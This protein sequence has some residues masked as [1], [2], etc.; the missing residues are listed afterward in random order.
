[1][2]KATISDVVHAFLG[3]PRCKELLEASDAT[4]YFANDTTNEGDT[5]TDE[6]RV[7]Q[8]NW[9]MAKGGSRPRY[10]FALPTP[11]HPAMTVYEEGE[12]QP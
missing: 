10:N 8:I 7:A 4:A 11:E 1:M 3:D 9:D 2:E 5:M 6:A 12:K